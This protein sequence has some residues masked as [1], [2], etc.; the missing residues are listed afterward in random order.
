[1][2]VTACAVGHHDAERVGRLVRERLVVGAD[3]RVA[4]RLEQLH[5]L[6]RRRALLDAQGFE[7]D[8]LHHPVA[9]TAT[10]NGSVRLGLTRRLL[11]AIVCV[12][13]VAPAA[14]GT[15]S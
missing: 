15:G 13:P 12:H 7:R 10:G 9:P 2:D 5:L 6:E 4:Q 8:L 3:V 14:T 11:S 1:V